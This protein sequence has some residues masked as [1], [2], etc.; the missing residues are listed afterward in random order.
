MSPAAMGLAT[1]N[2]SSQSNGFGGNST[3]ASAASV[4]QAPS[5]PQRPPAIAADGTSS[6]NS[7]LIAGMP[8][9]QGADD[10]QT[11]P[12][13]APGDGASGGQAG[14]M[15]F[16]HPATVPQPTGA[17]GSP[18]ATSSAGGSPINSTFIPPGGNS[19]GGGGIA[20]V[21][22]RSNGPTIKILNDQ[23]DRSLWEF[24]YDMHKE[25][26][27]A[28]PITGNSAN[29]NING[30]AGTAATPTDP[31]PVNQGNASNNVFVNPPS[32]SMSAPAVN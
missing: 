1:Y 25:A 26:M 3:E 18:V 7:D 31:G 29:G 17:G 8:A 24:V 13:T 27:A 23:R 22:S 16:N 14:T 4:G 2:D 11:D 30:G 5:F 21:A 6:N 9:A 28:I 20:G 10:Q 19:F 15:P 32:P 12:Q